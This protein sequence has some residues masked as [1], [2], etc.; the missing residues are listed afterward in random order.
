VGPGDQRD[1]ED[2]DERIDDFV[3][4]LAEARDERRASAA[5]HGERVAAN[6]NDKPEDENGETH[7][8][9]ECASDAA[10][11][12]I[13]AL[14]ATRLRSLKRERPRVRGLSVCWT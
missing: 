3:R 4:R 6:E 8:R 10:G 1:G 11:E 12:L 5:R 14:A 2:G 13:G 7:G 9:S